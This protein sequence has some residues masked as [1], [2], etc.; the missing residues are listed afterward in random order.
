MKARSNVGLMRRAADQMAAA[1]RG[2]DTKIAHVTKGE[3]VLSKSFMENHEDLMMRLI[4]AMAEAGIDPRTRIV[5]TPQG[6]K[7]PQTGAE[8]FDEGGG[9]ANDGSANHGGSD[10]SPGSGGGGGFGDGSGNDGGWTDPG[11]TGPGFDGPGPGKGGQSGEGGREGL[12]YTGIGFIDNAIDRAVQ[13]PVATGINAAFGVVAGP[14]GWANTLSGLMGGPTV[15]GMATAAGRAATSGEPGAPTGPGPGP[16]DDVGGG[17]GVD[18]VVSIE[19]GPERPVSR[20][21]DA[22]MPVGLLTPA[23]NRLSNRARPTPSVRFNNR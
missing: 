18:Q 16:G 22:Y 15:G 10:T 5:G 8:E 11:V 13:N 19:D 20:T 23:T 4:D 7:N 17:G 1:G 6:P 14:L 2:G 3:M 12:G 21:P 9:G